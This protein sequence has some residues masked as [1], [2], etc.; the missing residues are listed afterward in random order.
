MWK[1]IDDFPNYEVSDC[2][3][4]RMVRGSR[5]MKGHKSET[6]EIKPLIK[7]G[8]YA[9]VC[10]YRDGSRKF[11]SVHRIVARA[12]VPNPD[13]LPQVNHKDE[14]KS[15]NSAL[16]LEW[17]TARYNSRYGTASQ[18]RI[19]SHNKNKTKRAEQ[20]VYQILDGKVVSKYRSISQAARCVGA[21]EANIRACLY[22]RTKSCAG[23]EWARVNQ[24]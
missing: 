14:N 18:R 22:G 4:R 7:R 10:L 23:Y 21:N 15:N 17:C 12:F 16:N 13:N 6:L 9:Q 3:S 11:V 1:I 20:P 5:P 24:D 2:A 19:L 8:G